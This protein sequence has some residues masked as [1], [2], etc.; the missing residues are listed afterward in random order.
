MVFESLKVALKVYEQFLISFIREKKI[1]WQNSL[2][3]LGIIFIK[4]H[5]VRILN[6]SDSIQID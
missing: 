2:H 4:V 1:N 3:S 5:I 6:F